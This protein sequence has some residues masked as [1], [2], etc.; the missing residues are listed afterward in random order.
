MFVI[1][2]FEGTE[3][4][5]PAVTVVVCDWLALHPAGL[6]YEYVIEYGPPAPALAGEKTDP[7]IPAPENTPPAGVPTSVTGALKVV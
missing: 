5:Y 1:F 7:E 3:Q 6:V 4:L 2:T